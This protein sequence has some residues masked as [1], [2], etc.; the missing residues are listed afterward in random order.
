M[1]YTYHLEA[2]RGQIRRLEVA[3]IYDQVRWNSDIMWS[4]QT[5]KF[6]SLEHFVCSSSH[7]LAHPTTSTYA[8]EVADVALHPPHL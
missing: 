1:K 6:L 5:W 8:V 3:M 4:C 2:L 7:H